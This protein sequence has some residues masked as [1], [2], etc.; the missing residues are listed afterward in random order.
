LGPI[1]GGQLSGQVKPV[2]E[3]WDRVHGMD[4]VQVE[5][6]ASQPYSINIWAVGLGPDFYIASGAGAGSTWVKHFEADP[7]V[8]LRL[9]RDLF[10]LTAVRVDDPDELARVQARYIEKYDLEADETMAA[11]AW[12]YRLDRR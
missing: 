3:T 5:T 10:E 4:T 8:R 6:R 1:P 7:R 2:P 9:G 12:I 11:K